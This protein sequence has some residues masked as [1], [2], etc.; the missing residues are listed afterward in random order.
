MLHL[1]FEHIA[2]LP[3]SL[4]NSLEFGKIVRINHRIKYPLGLATRTNADVFLPVRIPLRLRSAPL[5][6]YGWILERDVDAFFERQQPAEESG[7]PPKPTY[8]CPFCGAVRASTAELDDHARFEHSVA[9]P[10]LLMDGREPPRLA[11]RNTPLHVS[12]IHVSNATI[13]TLRVGG[14]QSVVS[15]LDL[16][17]VLCRLRW[18]DVL[19]TLSNSTK[20][21][22]VEVS[23]TYHLSFR[24][25]DA[26]SLQSVE[27][28]FHHHLTPA[29]LSVR[30]IGSFLEDSRCSGAGSEYA[31]ALASY[32]LGVLHKEDPEQTNL[33]T[34][35]TQYRE[36]YVRAEEGLRQ[37][38]RPLAR[39]IAQVTRF[40]LND[41]SASPITT[42][43]SELDVAYR[44][45]R[46]PISDALPGP[47]GGGQKM[48]RICPIDHDTSQIL[49][50]ATR[51]LAQA[52]WSSLLSG[53][54]RLVSRAESLGA[55]DQQ[56]AA[57]IWAACALRLQAL[58][59]AVEPLRMIVATYPFDR[60]AAK[61]LEELTR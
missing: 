25:A 10:F 4:V 36:D 26:A 7:P 59:E 52:R 14:Q 34:A 45:L 38:E 54:C 15:P 60:W 27:R 32:A 41:F 39:L 21:N 37:V 51:M 43:Y 6:T 61:L 58:D 46:D 19:L 18:E 33:T 47:P 57:A 16:P 40:S 11:R 8:K 12:D 35:A 50:L 49:N 28:S 3:K 20:I 24:V 22:V 42:G 1:N 5:P 2:I 30:A 29:G 56:K 23:E 53:E 9:R 55:V 48:Y 44:L 31:E 17:E 13:A